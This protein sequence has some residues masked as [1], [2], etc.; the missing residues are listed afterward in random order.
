STKLGCL[1]RTAFWTLNVQRTAYISALISNESIH[2][3]AR[4]SGAKGI[5][6]KMP[7]SVAVFERSLNMIGALSIQ[8]AFQLVVRKFISWCQENN[9]S[10]TSGKGRAS[11]KFDV[12]FR[13]QIL[14][15]FEMD[16]RWIRILGIPSIYP[17]TD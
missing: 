4:I 11:L 5:T 7:E 12:L 13:P 16:S 3:I 2:G 1:C 8:N 14:P 17:E 10:G 6:I 9:A 15:S